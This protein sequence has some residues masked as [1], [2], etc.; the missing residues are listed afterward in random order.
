[1][2]KMI[3]YKAFNKHMICRGVQF[4]VGKIYTDEQKPKL[5]VVGFTFFNRLMDCFNEYAFDSESTIICE[6][7]A[8]GEIV[9]DGKKQITNDIEIIRK[10]EW[11]EICNFTNVGIGNTNALNTGNNN[12]GFRNSGNGNTGNFNS[13]NK[14]S[15]SMNSGYMNGGI[16]NSGDRNSGSWNSGDFNKGDYNSGYRN[17]GNSNSGDMNGGNGN[18]GNN[19]AGNKNSGRN[20]CGNSNTGNFNSGNFNTGCYNSKSYNSGHY[21]SGYYNSGNYNSG[22]TNVGHG[23]MGNGNVGCFNQ[24]SYNVGCHNTADYCIGDFNTKNMDCLSLFN[25]PIKR[26]YFEFWR[27]S[28][29]LEIFD[30]IKLNFKK[31]NGE[32]AIAPLKGAYRLWWDNLNML[33]KE[34][35]MENPYFNAEVFKE[36]TSI[37]VNSKGKRRNLP[38]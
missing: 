35:I 10:L 31:P 36:I 18:S 34:M 38:K 26:R 11:K 2:E 30:S 15:G 1:M 37:V 17:K 32:T 3:G 12:Q 24:G 28:I 16:K 9:D 33:D 8:H 25:K 13:G 29:V 6:V 23:N 21:N 27:N 22:N 20:N 19:N 14:N 7:V 4:E 5:N